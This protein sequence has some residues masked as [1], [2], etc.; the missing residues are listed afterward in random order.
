MSNNITADQ[1]MNPDGTLT[2]GCYLYDVFSEEELIRQ[3]FTV[4][5]AGWRRAPVCT[6][7]R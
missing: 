6:S 4:T 1:L 3:G 5:P 7:R 2:I